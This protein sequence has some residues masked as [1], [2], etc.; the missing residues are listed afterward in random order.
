MSVETEGDLFDKTAQV[1]AVSG[2]G[3]HRQY[4]QSKERRVKFLELVGDPAN[5]V[6][7]IDTICQMT[8]VKYPTYSKWRSRYPEFAYEVDAARA[9]SA[10]DGTSVQWK[11][12]F[13]S[14]RKRFFDM[15]SAWFHLEIIDVLENAKP[16]SITL[17]LLPPG[18]GK[19]TVL[20]DWCN[21]KLG[22]DPTHRIG[23]ASEKV[24]HSKKCLRRIKS[25]MTND[26]GAWE[27]VRRFGPFEP[28]KG[29]TSD[30]PFGSVYFNVRKKGGHDER[31]YNFV[32]LGIGAAVAGSR[33]DTCILDDIQSV[34]SIGKTEGILETIRQ[35]FF[36]RTFGNVPMG[37]VIIIGTRVGED[38]IY[39]RLMDEVDEASGKPLLDRVIKY[40]AIRY[41]Y[42]K[43]LVDEVGE[44]VLDAHGKAQYEQI[45]LWPE[46]YTLAD[47]DNMRRSVGPVAWARNFQ[48]QGLIAGT[49]T[50][51]DE[52]LGHAL[53]E[54]MA[55]ESDIPEDV[56][57]LC[58][59][60]DPAVGGQNS[61]TV[62]GWAPE[63][64]YMLD[65]QG[66]WGL[67]NLSQ[68]AT[69]LDVMMT[70]WKNRARA[71]GVHPTITTLVVEHMGFQKS[72]A[73]DP[74]ILDLQRKFGFAIVEHQT[75]DNK[76]DP[77]IGITGMV[78]S[79]YQGQIVLPAATDV[80]TEQRIKPAIMEFRA[81][82]PNKRGN[83]LKQ[84]RVMSFW[85]GW[86]QWINRR[87]TL[88]DPTQQG[89]PS[90]FKTDGLPWKS[91]PRVPLLVGAHSPFA[92]SSARRK[93][94]RG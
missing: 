2:G 28:Q 62:Q 46:R 70:A 23:Y 17:I 7:N 85:F 93:M 74:A 84:D 35:D 90:Q 25:R 10:I 5:R 54:L 21:K 60:L 53:N 81:W 48:Q 19:T 64:C 3:R 76:N 63:R 49:T 66:D 80:Q 29:I 67:T 4:H 82:R 16:G 45:L 69:I 59:T 92:G 15:D 58:F 8:G 13:A 55:W 41:D 89:G 42:D 83:K 24:D 71:D 43:V 38:D 72:I 77:N 34:K 20:E 12:D 87:H 1:A 52:V 86:L 36:S 14:Y 61:V 56:K 68:I 9:G 37:R 44:Q 78:Y 18:H 30:Q 65:S 73:R 31:D 75:Q 11:G 57:E 88:L 33:F 91:M 40:P 26:G 32:A 22:E 27:Y 47:Y 79:M 50:F 39:Q 6:L 94:R 51:D